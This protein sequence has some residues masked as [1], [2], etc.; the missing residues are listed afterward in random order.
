M[1]EKIA[2]T[3]VGQTRHKSK[4][5][6]INT[7]ELVT[8]A[9][10][11][12]LNDA[13][14]TMKDIDFVVQGSFEM[15]DGQYLPDMWIVPEFG[16]VGKPGFKLQ[17]AGTTGGVA[18]A[19]AF[20]C[21]AS[22]LFNNVLC[23]TWQKM[24]EG[25]GA[26]GRGGGGL[27]EYWQSQI[28]MSPI[29]NF[30]RRTY[31]YLN[32][33]GCTEEHFAITRV[34]QDQCALKNPYA[35]LRLNTTVEKVMESAVLVWPIR[36][37]HMCP[38]TAGAAAII[39]SPEKQAKKV[40]KKPVWVEDWFCTH[41]GG[42]YTMAEE[43]TLSTLRY[44][45]ETVYKRCG[46]T[47]VLKDIQVFEIYEPCS[48]AEL[49]WME[50]VGVCEDWTAWKLMEQ[51]KIGID[52]E[53][54]FNPSGGVTATNPIGATPVIRIIEAALQIRGDAGEHQV[55][56]NVNRALATGY[57]GQ[58]ENVIFLLRKSL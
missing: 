5:P 9:V 3:G 23:V 42:A 32:N 15:A 13:H 27:S 26:F 25:Q 2:I 31:A 10:D 35:Q 11:A 44:G 33:S 14:L 34:K 19:A 16:G 4:R 56:H 40:T 37:L 47:N 58:G 53:I 39:V 20:H 41:V 43:P 48:P 7:P 28:P 22:G 50:E 54:P 38:S 45:C 17:N 46:I 52:K 51:G 24:D 29:T 6:D 12:A 8:E 55:A 30:A 49:R 1:A 21:A 18:A 36:F 57:G